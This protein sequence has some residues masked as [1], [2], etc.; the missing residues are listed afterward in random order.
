[1]AFQIAARMGFRQGFLKAKPTIL[2]PIMSL[3][4]EGP[5]EFQGQILATIN[6]RRGIIVGTREESSYCIIDAEVPLSE[7]FGY[8]TVLRSATQGKAEFQMEFNRY[9]PVPRNISEELMKK[10]SSRLLPE[11]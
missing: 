6:Q 9:S 4:V 1:M 2:E 7:M 11:E 3:S 5:V 10:Y 8:S